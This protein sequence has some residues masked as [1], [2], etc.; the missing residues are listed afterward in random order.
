MPRPSSGFQ[1]AAPPSTKLIARCG[2]ENLP[3]N[4]RLTLS[5]RVMLCIA[6]VGCAPGQPIARDILASSG[7]YSELV[8]AAEHAETPQP[9]ALGSR[10]NPIKARGPRGEREFLVRLRC[11]DGRAPAFERLGSTAPGEDGDLLD[12]YVVRCPSGSPTFLLLMDMYHNHRETGPLTP[13]VVLEYLPARLAQGCPPQVADP[14]SSRRYVFTEF[15]VDSAAVTLHR[16]PSWINAP[17][18]GY[19]HTEFVVDTL[20]RVESTSLSIRADSKEVERQARGILDTLQF[21]PAVH[22]AG[23]RVRQR[24]AG[25]LE[26]SP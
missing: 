23:C 18:S 6:V 22:H 10:E 25:A 16:I 12:S 5:R 14:D 26:F 2:S 24:V 13:F 3:P 15:E 11:P 4:K 8:A 21:R 20:G 9:G 19:A 7:P 17:A 1:S